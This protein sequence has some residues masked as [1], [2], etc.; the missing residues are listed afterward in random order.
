M[1]VP[2]IGVFDSGVGG[3]SVLHEIRRLLPHVSLV[4]FA[5]QKHVPYGS[6]TLDEVQALSEGITRFLLKQECELVVVAC[7]TASAA[8]LHGLRS[9]FPDTQFVGME[10]AVKPA[11]ERTQT[12]KVGVLATPATFQGEL[13]ASVVDRF[14]HG[15]EVIEIIVPGLVEL[16]EVGQTDVETVLRDPLRSAV[17]QSIDTLVLACTHYSFVIPAI[18]RTLGSSVNVIDPAPAV[19]RQ[20][21]RLWE[22][23]LRSEGTSMHAVHAVSPAASDSQ[24]SADTPRGTARGASTRYITSGDPNAFLSAL[25]TL[26]GDEGAAEP[27]KWEAGSLTLREN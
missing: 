20:T 10:P 23:R 13:F 2:S 14:A 26:V 18:R 1:T 5:D 21:E 11:A 24:K 4:Y 8:A 12:R 15:V 22:S 25:F 6:R 19:A 16:I 3:L 9:G 27:A 17:E 7:N